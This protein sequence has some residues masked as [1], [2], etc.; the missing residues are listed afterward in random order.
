MLL[1]LS[2]VRVI[3]VTMRIK[4]ERSEKHEN[5]NNIVYKVNMY[6]PEYT[7]TGWEKSLSVVIVDEF[8]FDNQLN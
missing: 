2:Y 1:L 3:R 6:T 8:I 4:R 5:G 7:C